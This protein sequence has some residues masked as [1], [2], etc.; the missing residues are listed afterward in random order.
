MIERAAPP[1]EERRARVA[2]QVFARLHPDRDEPTDLEQSAIEKA[3]D[4]AF[5]SRTNICDLDWQAATLRRLG[6]EGP[7]L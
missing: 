7:T 2:V 3:A 5:E 6:Y 4:A 1:Y